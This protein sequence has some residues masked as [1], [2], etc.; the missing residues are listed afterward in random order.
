MWEL[1]QQILD[2]LNSDIFQFVIDA[3]AYVAIKAIGIFF[4]IAVVVLDVL[5][6][7][8]ESMLVQ[9]GVG[10]AINTALQSVDATWL[11]LV[12]AVHGIEAML[13][14]LNAKIVKFVIGFI[15]L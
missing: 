2:W 6:Q 11:Q 15:G 8:V 13:I 5:W 1:L 12:N 14:V 9:L 7:V 10:E 4:V 3:I